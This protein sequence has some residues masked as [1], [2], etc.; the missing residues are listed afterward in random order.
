MHYLLEDL[1]IGWPSGRS[2]DHGVG[3]RYGLVGW[4]ITSDI[5][6][7]LIGGRLGGEDEVGKGNGNGR[8]IIWGDYWIV[9]G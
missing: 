8:G 7:L 2:Q 1:E 3:Q 4:D 6:K 9:A 5:V